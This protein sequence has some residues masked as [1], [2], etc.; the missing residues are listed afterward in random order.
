MGVIKTGT[1]GKIIKLATELVETSGYSG[2][3]CRLY[4]GGMAR[5]VVSCVALVFLLLP[6]PVGAEEY[7][8]V[9]DNPARHS[10]ERRRDQFSKDFAYFVYPIAGSVP[11]LGTASGAGATVANVGETNADFT[12]FYIDGDFK[13]TGV[14]VTDL[15][16]ISERLVANLGS[17]TYKVSPMVFRRGMDSSKDDYILPFW[18]GYSNVGQLALTFDERRYEFYARFMNS[19][20]SLSRILDKNHNEFSNVDKSLHTENSLNLGFWLDITDDVQ[21]PRKGTRVEG[22]RHSTFEQQ[23]MTSQFNIYDVNLTEYIPVGLS[24]TWAFNAY[25]ST[26]EKQSSA[27]TDRTELRNAI[28]L[29]CAAITNPAS[30]AQCDATEKQFLDDR[31]AYNQFGMAS[32]L[33]GTQRLR[34][35]PNGRFFAGKSVFYGTELR[36]NLTDEKTLMDWF[37]LRGLRTNLQVAFFAEVGGVAESDSDLHKQMRPSYGAGFRALFS[38][39]TIRL[40]VGFGDEGGQMQLFLDY[41]WSLFSVDRPG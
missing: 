8:L 5:S 18:D 28:G 17:Y 6:L 31:I 38:G 16:I 11:G 40:D 39:V 37:F 3:I 27:S 7:P 13:A 30:K 32:Y 9:P 1:R 21:D 35:Y 2:H 29:N 15:H 33:G 41:P 25:Y 22:V 20:G 10:V 12:G 4:N 26:A 36:L 24:S 34:S 23:Y 14:A 19:S